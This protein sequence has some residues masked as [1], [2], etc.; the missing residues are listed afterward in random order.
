MRPMRWILIILLTSGSGSLLGAPE[1]WESLQPSGYVNDFADVLPSSVEDEMTQAIT[2]LRQA[3][4]TEIAVV[5]LDS[6]EGGSLEDFAVRLAER[7]KIGRAGQDDGVLF[8]IA[9]QERSLRIEVGYGL[10]PLLPDSR[11]GQI[12]DTHVL[13]RLRDGDLPG[14]IRAGTLALV[15]EIATRQGLD[16]DALAQAPAQPPSSSESEESIVPI[17][18]FIIFV[19]FSMR[20]NRRGRGRRGSGG[21][22][23]SGGGFGSGSSGSFGGG[24]SFG[25]FSGGSFGGGGASGRW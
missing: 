24:G 22:W 20:F 17:I 2:A 11:A 16:P 19:L 9:L 4:G 6:L 25:G 21:I 1:L 3:S 13:P 23:I 12:R 8:L 5:T 14:G 15:R 7:W 10:E 18:I